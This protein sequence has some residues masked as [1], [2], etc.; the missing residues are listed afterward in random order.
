VTVHIDP[1]DDESLTPSLHLPNR[2][3]L[4]TQFLHHWQTLYPEIT[5]WVIHYVEGKI[6]IDLICSEKLASMVEFQHNLKQDLTRFEYPVN[7]RIYIDET[8]AS[9]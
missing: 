4:E 7:I 6:T 8:P 5:T 3:F 2:H 9:C 1:E